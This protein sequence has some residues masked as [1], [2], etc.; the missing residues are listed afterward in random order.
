MEVRVFLHFLMMMLSVEVGGFLHFFC[1]SQR[2]SELFSWVTV[3]VN[4][5]FSSRS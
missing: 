5:V 2:D 1:L 3:L 4:S